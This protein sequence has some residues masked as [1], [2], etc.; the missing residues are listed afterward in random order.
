MAI[1]GVERVSHVVLF[2]CVGFVPL[3]AASAGGGIEGS[4]EIA[5]VV[6]LEV[7]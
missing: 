3:Y 7:R 5:G 6:G 4:G 2:A 1:P